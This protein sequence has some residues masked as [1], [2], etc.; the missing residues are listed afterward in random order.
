MCVCRKVAECFISIVGEGLTDAQT[1]ELPRSEGREGDS[2]CKQVS[3][4]VVL[5]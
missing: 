2:P 1:S 4:N 5:K 3:K